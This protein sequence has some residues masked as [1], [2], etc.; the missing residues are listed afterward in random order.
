MSTLV[1]NKLGALFAVIKVIAATLALL[2]SIPLYARADSGHRTAY[3]EQDAIGEIVCREGLTEFRSFGTLVDNRRTVIAVGHF[4]VLESQN[5][6]ISPTKC[7][8]RLGGGK[9]NQISFVVLAKG[10]GTLER[11][12]SRAVD[13]A[14]LRLDREAPAHIQPLSLG[15]NNTRPD[16]GPTAVTRMYSRSGSSI[17]CTVQGVRPNSILVWHNCRSSRGFSGLPLITGS[18]LHSE[19]YAVHVGATKAKGQA[20]RI[21][22]ALR[23]AI[24]S[25]K[26][27]SYRL[28]TSY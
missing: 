21:A 20:V 10:G 26:P 24:L 11:R 19:V 7:F 14:V 1:T 9:Q 25:A 12:L 22:G 23:A 3:S 5:R 13:W 16:T 6:E 27:S 15:Q 4:N 28:A 17:K 18:D 2:F 8:V